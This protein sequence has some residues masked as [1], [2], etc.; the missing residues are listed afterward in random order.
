MTPYEAQQRKNRI[1]DLELYGWQFVCSL[2]DEQFS[3]ACNGCGPASWPEEKRRKLTKWLATFLPAFDGHDCD[4][5][6]RNDGSRELFDAANR[7]LKK[8]FVLVADN[9]YSWF[10][11]V[12]YLARRAG[13]LIAALCQEFGWADWKKAYEEHKQKGKTK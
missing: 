3:T 12:R 9:K 4:F 8:N 6:Y 11:P 10:N 13:K 5:T 7:R 1:R 2:T